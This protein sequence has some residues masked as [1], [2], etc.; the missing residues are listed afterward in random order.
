MRFIAQP[1]ALPAAAPHFKAHLQPPGRAL[2][3]Q[4]RPQ[5]AA[6]R[7]L[8]RERHPLAGVGLDR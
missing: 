5:R 4:V 8:G 7:L 1:K 3:A 2:A 6:S